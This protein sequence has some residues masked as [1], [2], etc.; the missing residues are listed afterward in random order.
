MPSNY[1]QKSP[2][3]E[4]PRI[5]YDPKSN[6]RTVD[7]Q[8]DCA[9]AASSPSTHQATKTSLTDAP[10]VI[11]A[12][13]F[14]CVSL[15]ANDYA[16]LT[17]NLPTIIVLNQSA[18][19]VVHHFRQA[20]P[21]TDVPHVW[22]KMWGK[23]VLTSTLEQLIT[24]GLLTQKD[25]VTREFVENS[26]TLSAWLHLTDRCNLRCA[27]CYLPHHR[28]DMPRITAHTALDAIFRSAITHD[29]QE[30]KLKYAG[31]EPMLRFPL[32]IELHQRAQ[33]LANRHNLTLEGVILSNGTLLTKQ[34]VETMK[35]LGIHL[36][37][38]LD[39]LADFHDRQRC[40]TNGRGS[41]ADVQRAIDLALTHK[42]IPDISIT[43]SA[44]NAEGLPTL[45][46]WIL[47][48]D[49][50]FSL[51]FYRENDL[52]VTHGDL[53]LAEQKINSGMLAAFEVIEANLP[54]RSL[55]ASLV[56]RANLSVPHLFTCGAGRSY[57]VFDHVGG[58]AKCQMQISQAVIAAHVADPLTIVR[59]D[60]V[61]I[62]NISVEEKEGCR[63]CEWKYWC[64]GGC[65]LATYRATGRYDVKS[66][67]CNIYKALYPKA[68][69]LEGLRLL[70][71]ID[72][73]NK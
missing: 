1:D 3:L 34:I 49:L 57:L 2:N 61:A 20:R 30:V 16:V 69:R 45:I 38:S 55:L 27:Y 19:T 59:K 7:D 40:Y 29:Y 67:N 48:R 25:S 71:F 36:M 68:V 23:A 9:C 63:D 5:L 31:G 21:I 52:S 58:V 41:F 42:L 47:A 73:T 8:C 72:E 24:H 22:Y 6:N 18:L 33:A 60:Q 32:V 12:G 70:K 43:V 46:E 66:P 28:V 56:D 26:T 44:R 13:S 50:P 65:P 17:P 39:G 37:I 15:T 14:P 51:N 10:E 54:H 62:Q 11:L 35:S 4:V 53:R 64:T